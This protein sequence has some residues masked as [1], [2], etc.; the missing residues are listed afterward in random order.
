M[1]GRKAF[2]L[3]V[4]PELLKELEAWAQQELRSVNGQIEYLLRQAVQ[5]RR[6]RLLQER[7]GQ[8]RTSADSPPKQ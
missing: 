1:S 6:R 2:L 8:P 7:Q 5:Q 4:D 3:R